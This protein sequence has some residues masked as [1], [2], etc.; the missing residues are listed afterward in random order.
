MVVHMNVRVTLQSPDGRKR[1][2]GLS[3]LPMSLV[4]QGDVNGG[5]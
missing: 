1:L 2:E 3:C 5:W 4:N